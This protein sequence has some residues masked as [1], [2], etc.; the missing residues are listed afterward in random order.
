[1]TF[2]YTAHVRL[3]CDT[4]THV[5][6]FGLKV[7]GPIVRKPNS[8]PWVVFRTNPV[9][10]SRLKVCVNYSEKKKFPFVSDWKKT[11]SGLSKR[12]PIST[13]AWQSMTSSNKLN[14]IEAVHLQCS[15]YMIQSSHRFGLAASRQICL[16]PV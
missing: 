8:I 13:D 7:I 4:L 6:L 10:F 9:V 3:V 15:V 11:A 16:N 2:R 14:V 1:M 5:R 12:L